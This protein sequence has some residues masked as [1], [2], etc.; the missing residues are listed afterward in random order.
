LFLAP[1]LSAQESAT[2]TPAFPMQPIQSQL[3]PWTFTATQIGRFLGVIGIAWSLKPLFGLISDFLP[4]RGN[5]R[6]PYLLLSTGATAVAFLYLG[7]VWKTTAIGTGGWFAGLLEATPDQPSVG[8]IGW[9]LVLAG[10][11]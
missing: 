10:V 1:P 11:G 6:I 9:L 5:R 7:A 2:R 8:Q 4:I 3:Q